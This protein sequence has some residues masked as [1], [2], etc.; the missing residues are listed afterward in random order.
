MSVHINHDK[1][2]NIIE[3]DL[4]VFD[5]KNI[6]NEIK[7]IPNTIPNNLTPLEKT[8]YIYKKLGNLFC[9]DYRTRF[10]DNVTEAITKPL[11]YNYYINNFVS[12]I[13]M[14]IILNKLLNNINGVSS[15][16]IPRQIPNLRG[17]AFQEQH[18]ANEI[19]INNKKYLIDLALDL[20][21]IQSNCQTKYF[22]AQSDNNKYQTLSN[23][24]L[25]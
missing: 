23:N 7:N 16:I 13:P 20:Y 15:I 5:E 12:C 21:L 22:A 4:M 2:I 19:T 17:A 18:T 14:A 9:F 8:R 3:N 1:I 24:K 10:T 25:K 11:N 6:L